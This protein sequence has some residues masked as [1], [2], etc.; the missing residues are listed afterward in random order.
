MIR[1]NP[2]PNRVDEAAYSE[3]SLFVY[4]MYINAP[5][6]V[7]LFFIACS[8]KNQVSV[9][10]L[11][12]KE[13]ASQ[14]E[15]S[16][17]ASPLTIDNAR[18]RRPSPD[19]STQATVDSRQQQ[20][21]ADSS[22]QNMDVSVADIDPVTGDIDTAI[23]D[24]DADT[25]DI[26]LTDSSVDSINPDIKTRRLRHVIDNGLNAEPGRVIEEG[27]FL[28]CAP[29]LPEGSVV[30]RS[31]DG[32]E[33]WT[34]ISKPGINGNS[35]N[36]TS[37]SLVWFKGKLYVGTW[38][39][40]IAGVAQLFRANADAENASEI[41]WEAIT[42]DGFG[43]EN[44][45]GFTNAIVFD[46]YLYIGC[47]NLIEGSEIWRSASGDHGSFSMCI[48]KGWG[49]SDNSDTTTFYVYNNRLYAGTESVR[50]LPTSWKGTALYSTAGGSGPLT[51][52]KD[53]PDGYGDQS[54]T[55]TGALSVF[56][57]HMYACTWNGFG[58]QIWR[59]PMVGTP[60]TWT[61]VFTDGGDSTDND[62]C[63]AL[64]VLDDRIFFGSVGTYFS[65]PQTGRFYG[66][67]DGVNWTR[68][69]R[70]GFLE[71]PMVGII[72]MSLIDDKI[73][74]SVMGSPGLQAPGQQW[75]YE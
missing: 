9:W 35:A 39:E 72:G 28:Y 4:F 15:L 26:P 3:Q 59:T 17:D 45:D 13:D 1:E 7:A 75:V 64:I 2:T 43:N 65:D 38:Q 62:V 12:T 32:G 23:D 31:A 6:L 36:V 53:S 63:Q 25:A 37:T 18:Q 8:G 50:G 69:E 71:A 47:Y 21:S 30:Y 34:P 58:M 11:P 16:L 27:K 52:T 29:G 10:S 44:N 68:I 61:K 42:T 70:I 48:T 40:K 73:I 54:N 74:I 49:R 51:W 57:D 41:V 5:I 66:S 22:A 46:G 67:E 19:A 20:L 56:K 14:R 24:I 55:N 33:T 60:W